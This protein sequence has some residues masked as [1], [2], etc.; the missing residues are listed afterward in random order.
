VRKLL[1]A[2]TV[3]AVLS[4]TASGV[5]EGKALDGALNEAEHYSFGMNAEEMI[6]AILNNRFI[7]D[8]NGII[9]NLAQLFFG[10]VKKSMG[11][12]TVLLATA[13]LLSLSENMK[14]L[15]GKVH[16]AVIT[17]IRVIFAVA[18]FKNTSEYF[19]SISSTLNSVSSFSSTLMPLLFTALAFSGAAGSCTTLAPSLSLLTGTMPCV[20]TTVIMSLIS[21]GFSV[22]T[23]NGVLEEKKLSGLTDLLKSVAS[24]AIGAIFTLLSAIIAISGIAANV[25]DGIGM[26]SIK[27]AIGSSVPIIG[28]SVGDS[29]S[30]VLASGQSLK[31]AVGITGLIAIIGIIII[32]LLNFGC[33]R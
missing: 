30:L 1:I 32:P 23:V 11:N 33:V 4:I 6:D 21:V 18:L 24:F 19:L 9:E 3:I 10:S 14:L 2:L 22:G 28:G 26:R 5:D 29:L 7:L 13:I 25:Y 27:Y 16:T 17:G 12:V 20:F 8:G 15:D 31:G